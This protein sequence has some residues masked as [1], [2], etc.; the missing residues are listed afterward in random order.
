MTAAY[1][2]YRTPGGLPATWQLLYAAAFN[3]PRDR[4]R[5]GSPEAAGE[6]VVPL[7]TLRRRP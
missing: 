6:F 1:E 3:G 7:N 2:R 5:H 4:Q